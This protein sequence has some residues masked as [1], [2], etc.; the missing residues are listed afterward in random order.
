MLLG[1]LNV[2]QFL[3]Q[4]P[5]HTKNAAIEHTLTRL[6][7]FHGFAVF[8]KGTYLQYLFKNMILKQFNKAM[9]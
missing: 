5:G 8:E 4:C 7:S 3:Q 6:L 9:S 1:T 2:L